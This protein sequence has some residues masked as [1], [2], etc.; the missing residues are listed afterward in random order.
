MKSIYQPSEDSY[1]LSNIIKNYLKDKKN[2]SRSVLDM[3]SGTGIQVQTCK[4][5]GFN[6][7]LAVDINKEVIKK[8]KKQRFKTIL[9]DL[10]NNINNKEKFD[11]IIFNPPYLPLDKREPKDSRINTTAGKKG[12]EIIIK[13]LIQA[14]KHLNKQGS[15]LLL[16]SS[17]SQPKTIL[18]KAKGLEYKIKLLDSKKLFFEE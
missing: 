1:L 17:L 12:Y 3:G 18:A 4:N 14:K 6:N 11:L 15:I 13:F 16:F 10:F 9:S 5:L 8:L 2:K 7:I